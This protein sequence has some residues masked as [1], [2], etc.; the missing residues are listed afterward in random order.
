[1]RHAS[2]E[3]HLPL[4]E[5]P[6]S[7]LEQSL[8]SIS[9]LRA[10]CPV[11]ELVPDQRPHEV[12]APARLLVVEDDQPVV[13]QANGP[14]PESDLARALQSRGGGPASARPFGSQPDRLNRSV[15]QQAEPRARQIVG[16]GGEIV[17]RLSAAK[18]DS[19]PRAK[20]RN[21]LDNRRELALMAPPCRKKEI[22]SLEAA[23]H[24]KAN[25][26]RQRR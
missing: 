8:R 24:S 19:R 20:R 9:V 15:I 16:F 22:L 17:G 13:V 25:E 5:R 14:R 21:T 7:L 1:M 4:P 18:D 3:Q 23:P 6:L 10:A 12:I 2:F 11:A 26:N